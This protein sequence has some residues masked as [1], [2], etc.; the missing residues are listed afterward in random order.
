MAR[1]FGVADLACGL[2]TE[3]EENGRQDR[4]I[5]W[6]FEPK[7]EAGNLLL[8]GTAE[9][10]RPVPTLLYAMAGRQALVVLRFGLSLVAYLVLA[11]LV[12]IVLQSLASWLFG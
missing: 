10:I 4:T 9:G 5:R 3:R 12:A 2:G 6:C 8:L 11:F 7:W 1:V